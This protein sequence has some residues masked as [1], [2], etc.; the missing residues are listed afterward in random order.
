MYV[1]ISCSVIT[2]C[3]T[4]SAWV[5]D[6]D[7]RRGSIKVHVC[8]VILL[9]VCILFVNMFEFIIVWVSCVEI[10]LRKLTFRSPRTM[11]LEEISLALDLSM[12]H[13]H[14]C[15]KLLLEFGGRYAQHNRIF[16]IARGI[17]IHKISVPLAS[18]SY[19]RVRNIYHYTSHIVVAIFT[20]VSFVSLYVWTVILSIQA[21]IWYAGQW[22]FSE[23]LR[24]K[25]GHIDVQHK[26]KS[27]H[28][29]RKED[30]GRAWHTVVVRDAETHVLLANQSN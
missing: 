5:M 7:A 13:E 16:S 25:S 18:N 12:D 11:I 8:S 20:K 26:M 1:Y 9:G 19:Y 27:K 22:P 4:N 23:A 14:F 28:W 24:G 6:F 15:Q 17:S 30:G 10:R 2:E 3:M 29:I 21:W